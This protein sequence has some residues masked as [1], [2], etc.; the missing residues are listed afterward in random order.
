MSGQHPEVFWIESEEG[1]IKIESVE[2][3]QDFLSLNPEVGTSRIAVI[4]DA[5]KLITQAAN[6]L[7]KTLEEPPKF[8]KII[9]T[10]SKPHHF[11]DT[12]LSRCVQWN[13]APPPVNETTD[14]LKCEFERITGCLPGPAEIAG[15]LKRSGMAPGKALN[16][17]ESMEDE[18]IQSLVIEDVNS[19]GQVIQKAESIARTKGVKVVDMLTEWEISLN[20]KY[21]EALNKG[22]KDQPLAIAKRRQVLREARQLADR[23]KIAISGQLVTESLG[24]SKWLGLGDR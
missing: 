5:D 23:S 2:E 14:L 11:L 4:V 6:R 3:M 9:L 16:I 13:I 8:G 22:L 7:L 12:I 17:C 1:K 21:I 10:T 18:E 15:I 24:S 20:K 19:L